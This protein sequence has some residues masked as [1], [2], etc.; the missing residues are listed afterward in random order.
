MSRVSFQRLRIRLVTSTT[1]Q[2]WAH[3]LS[4][5]APVLQIATHVLGQHRFRA[6][7]D[8][9]IGGAMGG[10]HV[11]DDLEEDEDED[12]LAG[13][14]ASDMYV[15]HNAFLHGAWRQDCPPPFHSAFLRKFITYVKRRTRCHLSAPGCGVQGGKRC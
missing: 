5:T 9:G 14:G 15:K 13:Q 12:N 10:G 1:D 8:S 6:A 2:S 3:R 11:A 4:T 7:G